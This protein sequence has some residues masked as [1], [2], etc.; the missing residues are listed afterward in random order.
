M[1]VY[2]GNCLGNC[3]G[4]APLADAQLRADAP[5]KGLLLNRLRFRCRA[6]GCRSAHRQEVQDHE[7]ISGRRISGHERTPTRRTGTTGVNTAINGAAHTSYQSPRSSPPSTTPRGRAPRQ[8]LYSRVGLALAAA[9]P[10]Y[11]TL[12]WVFTTQ[13]PIGWASSRRILPSIRRYRASCT[14]AATANGTG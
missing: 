6:A 1:G 3:L 4:K 7:R 11:T 2:Y 5:Q 9:S 13:H 12:L 10:K 8:P 14:C